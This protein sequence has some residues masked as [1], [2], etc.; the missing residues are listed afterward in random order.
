MSDPAVKILSNMAFAYN[1][2]LHAGKDDAKWSGLNLEKERARS[3]EFQSAFRQGY[4]HGQGRQYP[5]RPFRE[6]L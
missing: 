4:C 5:I 1:Q 3:F 2:G 6:E